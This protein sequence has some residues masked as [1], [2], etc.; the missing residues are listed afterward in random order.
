M[1]IC[2]DVDWTLRQIVNLVSAMIGSGYLVR[3]GVT[4]GKIY[5]SERIVFGPAHVRAVDIE[6]NVAVMPTVLVDRS[7]V[8]K[9]ISLGNEGLVTSDDV[10]GEYF[11]DILVS[12]QGV[13]HAVCVSELRKLIVF[14]LA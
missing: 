10:D 1:V 4:V 12:L 9:F 7:T 2:G 8:A 13:K 11:A 14:G 3:G 6:K 5:C